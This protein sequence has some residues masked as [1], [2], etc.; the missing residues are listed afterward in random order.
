MESSIDKITARQILD[1]RGW[2]TV[3][4]EVR[5]DCGITAR[6][7]V[8]SGA[9]TGSHEALELRDRDPDRYMGKGVLKAVE[10]INMIIGHELFGCD[11]LDQM[12]IDRRMIDRDGTPDKSKLGAN[13]ILAVSMAAARAA[14]RFCGLP[15]FRYLGGSDAHV[16]PV[17]MMNFLNGGRHADNKVD[18]Q[19][20]MIVPFGFTRYSR[21]LRAGTEIFHALRELLQAR[22]LPTRVGDEGGFAPELSANEKGLELL[23]TAIKSAGYVP[24]REVGLALDVAASEFYVKP[25]EDRLRENAENDFSGGHYHFENKDLSA[26]EFVNTLADWVSRYPVISIE[27]GC[28]EDDWAGWRLL[29]ERL[30]DKIQLVG[31]DLFTTNIERIHRGIEEAAANAV[32]IKL[33]QIGSVTETMNAMNYARRNGYRLIVSHRSGETEDPFIADLSV[34]MN[35]GQIKTGSLARSERTAKYN[36]LLRIEEDLG[37]NAVFSLN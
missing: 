26:E 21:A 6:A 36:Q 30:G 34:G 14:A 28:A 3:E 4:A 17:P 2:P 18:V 19:E 27:D 11:V 31:D 15:L 5:L 33:N 25:N 12:T 16:L 10:N 9:S 35:A 29:S 22:G 13:A 37:K 1:S 32:L 7:A 23:V 8:P 24:G 20:F